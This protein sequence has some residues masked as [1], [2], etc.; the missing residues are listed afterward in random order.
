MI[1]NISKKRVPNSALSEEDL[2]FIAQHVDV[3]QKEEFEG[4]K[5]RVGQ[6]E[7]DIKELR[8]NGDGSNVYIAE[9]TEIENGA[10]VTT[11]VTVDDIHEA[12]T[13]GKLIFAMVELARVTLDGSVI[14][15]LPLAQSG[16]NSYE[17]C[18][19]GGTTIYKINKTLFGGLQ[20]SKTSVE[21]SGSSGSD[22]FIVQWDG[23][24]GDKTYTEVSQAIAEH[25]IPVLYQGDNCIATF[26]GQGS[27]CFVFVQSDMWNVSYVT[28]YV[29]YSNNNW[30]NETMR[31]VKQITLDE[32][33]S[34]DNPDFKSAVLNC[35]PDADTMSFPIEETVSEVSEE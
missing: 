33:I 9:F 15:I 23:S 25:K 4:L 16:V 18:G 29:L 22:I 31:I 3:P 7:S 5:E 27:E 14:A 28:E 32:T 8:E 35:F 30:Q 12:Y 2:K 19:T 26:S 11:E 24:T 34:A 21:D 20:Y 17:F 6:N 13:S 1:G 10:A